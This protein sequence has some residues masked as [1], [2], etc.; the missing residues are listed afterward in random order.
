VTDPEGRERPLPAATWRPSRAAPRRDVILAVGESTIVIADRDG[1]AL[2]HWSLPAVTRIAG[3]GGATYTPGDAASGEELEVADPEMIDALD[4]VRAA[5]SR[6]Q[7]R[8]GSLRTVLL[9]LVLVLVATLAGLWLPDALARHAARVVPDAT[10][11]EIGT[12]LLHHMLRLT[13]PPCADSDGFPPLARLDA[14]VRGTAAG[15]LVLVPGGPRASLHLP[16]GIVVLRRTVFENHDDPAVAA[17]FVVS[18][19]AERAA[20]D[21]VLALLEAAGPGAALR[22]LT[23]G[24]LPETLLAAE[25]ARLAAADPAPLPPGALRAAFDAADVPAIPYARTLDAPG[26]TVLL[27]AEADR[28]TGSFA[29]I[30][31]DGDWIALQGA[32]SGPAS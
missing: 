20:R 32:C 31:E 27:L 28:P 24:T 21:P 9:A 12:V 19:A 17:G 10:R 3:R 25:A 1:Q 15:R 30:L 26:E 5:A 14:R 11:T 8:P 7:A 13:G 18:E 29:P 16:G 2:T 22:L 6:R 4:A 23:A